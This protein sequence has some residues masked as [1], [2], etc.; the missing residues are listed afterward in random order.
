LST[1]NKSSA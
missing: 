1:I